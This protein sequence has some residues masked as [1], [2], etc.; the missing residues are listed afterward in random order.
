MRIDRRFPADEIKQTVFSQ[1]GVEDISI[2]QGNAGKKGMTP[3]VEAMM[4]PYRRE[5]AE[6]LR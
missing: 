4:R 6:T 1:K 2:K 3:L 5:T